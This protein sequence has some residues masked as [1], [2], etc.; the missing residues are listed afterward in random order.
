M[1]ANHQAMGSRYQQFGEDIRQ[2]VLGISRVE[3][4]PTGDVAQAD[5]SRR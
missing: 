2:D 1:L 5:T 3:H 4:T